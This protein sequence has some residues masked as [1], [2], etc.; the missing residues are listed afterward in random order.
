MAIYPQSYQLDPLG[1]FEESVKINNHETV[2]YLF[3]YQAAHCSFANV[4]LSNIKAQ[5]FL[6]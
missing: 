6:K 3:R 2:G 4:W 1:I 5:G